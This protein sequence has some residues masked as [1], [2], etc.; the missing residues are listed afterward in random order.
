ME[1]FVIK[2]AIFKKYIFD[3]LRTNRK[4]QEK[5]NTFLDL[6]Q[7]LKSP[8]EKK[9]MYDICINCQKNIFC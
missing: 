4:K 2:L 5:K 7:A 6:K 9:N 1:R 3:Y 8:L